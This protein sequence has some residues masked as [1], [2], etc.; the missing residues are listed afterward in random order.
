MKKRVTVFGSAFPKDGESEYKDAYILGSLLAQK[1]FDVNTGGYNGIMEAVSRGVK[2]NGGNAVGI[3]LNYLKSKPNNFLHS[4]ISC[5]TL[6]ER[7]TKLIELGDA[8]I[9]LQGGTGTLL[10]LAVVW[11]FLNK[12]LMNDKP[13]ACHS[14]MW[15]EIG[16]ILNKQLVKEG[17]DIN[18]ISFFEEIEEMVEFISDRLNK[19]LN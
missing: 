6:F 3:T 18:R 11:E 7:I 13:V 16:T 12:G 19:V 1:G 9:I 10:E 2:D 17:R 8:Y 5:N 15:K 4:T 14:L